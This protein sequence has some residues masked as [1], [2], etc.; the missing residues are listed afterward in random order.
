M[1]IAYS[2]LLKI[3]RFGIQAVYGRELGVDEITIMQGVENIILSVKSRES[4]DF[5]KWITD[6]PQ[7]QELLSDARKCAIEEGL[8]DE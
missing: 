3:D 8:I 2:T 4:S 7:A 1:P 5:A 6:N